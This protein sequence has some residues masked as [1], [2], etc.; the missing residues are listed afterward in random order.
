MLWSPPR[1]ED[2]EHGSAAGLVFLIVVSY[3]AFASW[4]ICTRSTRNRSGLTC[5]ENARQPSRL[6]TNC[7]RR[8]ITEAAYPL[9]ELM[10][11]WLKDMA[12]SDRS[13]EGRGGKKD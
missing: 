12:I 13:E 2:A 10:W 9:R 3:T 6:R 11:H 5:G 4:P 1:V 8:A 7:R